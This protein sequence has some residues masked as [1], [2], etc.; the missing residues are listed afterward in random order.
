M[1]GATKPDVA[2]ISR[3]WRLIRNPDARVPTAATFID[4]LAIG[5]VGLSLLLLVQDKT[6]SFATAGA[7]AGVFQLANGAGA[8]VQGRLMDRRGQTT[9]LVPA[10]VLCA[11]SLAALVAMAHIRYPTLMLISVACVGGVS[12]PQVVAAMRALWTELAPDDERETAYALLG[13]LFELGVVAGP[14]VVSAAIALA[15]PSVAVLLGAGLAAC[16][17][18]V[19]SA[20]GASRRFAPQG[21]AASWA[22]PLVSPGIRTLVL[23]SAAFGVGVA[24]VRVAAPAL[25]VRLGEQQLS[26][27]L[28]A[29]LSLGSLVGG[30]AYGARRWRLPAWLRLVLIQGALVVAL[31]SAAIPRTP[32]ALALVLLVAGLLVAPFVITSSALIDDVAPGGTLTEAYSVTVMANVGGD[33]LGTTL[34]GTVV[35]RAGTAETFLVGAAV[36]GLGAALGALRNRTLKAGS[37]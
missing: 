30:L 6:G 20:T 25:A 18:L 7:V 27:L 1:T 35:E 8:T 15:S 36:M 2:G 11:L 17:G 9:V 19:F 34:A 5:M 14:M 23:A 10:A 28:L 16:A 4:S 22:G 13:I 26:G 21:E 31:G 24:C 12:F 33:A 37:A 29:A 3:Y 32:L